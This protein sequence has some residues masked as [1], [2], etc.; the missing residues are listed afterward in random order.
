MNQIDR[1]FENIDAGIYYCRYADDICMCVAG[2]KN[3]ADMALT[4]STPS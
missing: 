3:N 4:R 1:R 2:E